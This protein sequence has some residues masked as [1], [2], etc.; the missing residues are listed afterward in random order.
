MQRGGL[1]P[2]GSLHIAFTTLPLDPFVCPHDHSH[3]VNVLLGRQDREASMNLWFV[4]V[5]F[6]SLIVI[7]IWQ[8][9]YD[10]DR[11]SSNKIDL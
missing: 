4:G 2:T 10:E 5:I 3:P 7:K 6:V 9:F 11:G 8:L 1:G